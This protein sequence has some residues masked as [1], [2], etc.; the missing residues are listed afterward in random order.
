MRILSV[1]VAKISETFAYTKQQA[2][3]KAR[4][5]AKDL[6]KLDLVFLALSCVGSLK[7]GSSQ[8]L[9]PERGTR[10]ATGRLFESR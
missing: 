2:K 9:Y 8:A 10:F 5:R 3:I 4:L 1:V 6:N 7:F